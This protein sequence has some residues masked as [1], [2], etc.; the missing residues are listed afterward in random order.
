M[1]KNYWIFQGNPTGDFHGSS[2]FLRGAKVLWVASRYA[3]RINTDDIVFLWQSGTSAGF[4]GWGRVLEPGVMARD[5]VSG[6]VPK[7]R[8]GNNFVYVEVVE[9]FA[10]PLLKTVLQKDRELSELLIIKSPIGTNFPITPRQIARLIEK[11]EKANLPPPPALDPPPVSVP[12]SL[13]MLGDR[14]I[15][16]AADDALS[17][18]PIAAAIAGL[19]DNPQTEVPLTIAVN[20]P[21]GAGKSSLG[22]LIEEKLISKPAAGGP[23]PHVTTWFNAWMHDDAADEHHNSISRAFVADIARTMNARRHLV[24]RILFPLPTA[25]RDPDHIRTRFR[26]GAFIFVLVLVLLLF[27]GLPS[28]ESIKNLRPSPQGWLWV[29]IV[30]AYAVIVTLRTTLQTA[31]AVEHFVR[32]PSQEAAAGWL[33]NV[34]R[35]LCTLIRDNTPPGSRLV[36]FV[37]DLERCRP[38]G[39]VNLL[40]TIHQILADAP[41]AVV[42]M[43]DLPAVA[44]SATVKYS[45]LAENYTPSGESRGHSNAPETYG[46]LYIQ[47][48]VQLQFDLPDQDI[49]HMRSLISRSIDNNRPDP[50]PPDQPPISGENWSVRNPVIAAWNPGI[51]VV[52]F[53]NGWLSLANWNLSPIGLSV[54]LCLLPGYLVARHAISVA[55]PNSLREWFPKLRLKTLGTTLSYFGAAFPLFHILALIPV[56]VDAGVVLLIEF[57]IF[58][59]AMAYAIYYWL[60]VYI[61]GVRRFNKENLALFAARSQAVAFRDEGNVSEDEVDAIAETAQASHELATQIIREQRQLYL[62]NDSEEFVKARESALLHLRLRPRSLKRLINRLRLLITLVAARGDLVGEK[63]V[64]PAQL[65]KWVAIQERWPE[66]ANT[67]VT[68]PDLLVALEAVNDQTA[69]DAALPEHLDHLKEDTELLDTLNTEPQV[70]PAINS[71]IFMRSPER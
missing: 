23:V 33:K 59:L 4:Y 7:N 60:P 63:R 30:A 5:A 40:E 41:I 66:L 71:L 42:V 61:F 12:L 3:K 14:P 26:V 24:R 53:L 54:A 36:I 22:H 10:S 43:A 46:R 21:W 58:S 56:I 6:G 47:K 52:D 25:L 35:Q 1:A 51:R 50:S 20:A 70:G 44:A 8:R 68:H 64:E 45:D 29:L 38:P 28:L 16:R 69:M 57:T 49:G 48:L 31:T 27:L 55:C 13:K 11:L 9:E 2:P 67:I 39:S 65:G 17:F 34:R 32:N 19:I 62:A 37:D 15:Y 18:E